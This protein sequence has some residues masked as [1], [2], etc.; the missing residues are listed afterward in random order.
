MPER[1]STSA[2]CFLRILLKDLA[3]TQHCPHSPFHSPELFANAS[4][5]SIRSLTSFRTLVVFMCTAQYIVH[6][7]HSVKTWILKNR[8]LPHQKNEVFAL[9]GCK[10]ETELEISRFLLI[11]LGVQIPSKGRLCCTHE[12]PYVKPMIVPLSSP[13]ILFWNLTMILT[14][15]PNQGRKEEA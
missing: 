6:S 14:H 11:V 12:C 1:G 10:R 8:T 9:H 5:F 2:L 4:A 13:R 7:R 15:T 3:H